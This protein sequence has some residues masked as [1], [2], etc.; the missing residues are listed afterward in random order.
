[1]GCVG[2]AEEAD[3]VANKLVGVE[4][5]QKKGPMFGPAHASCK[6]RHHPVKILS[7]CVKMKVGGFRQLPKIP[8]L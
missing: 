7:S 2:R 6:V 1:M 3:H 8:S 4:F 5:S